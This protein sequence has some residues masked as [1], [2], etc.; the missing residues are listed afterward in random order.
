MVSCVGVSVC[1]G[2]R[3][4]RCGWRGGRCNRTAAAARRRRQAVHVKHNKSMK[5][6]NDSTDT[7]LV[8]LYHIWCFLLLFFVVVGRL[9]V[10]VRAQQPLQLRL[11]CSS[12][13]D[14]SLDST[15]L[16]STH[17][18]TS[19][20]GTPRAQG[21]T[22]PRVHRDV[23]SRTAVEVACRVLRGASAHRRLRQSGSGQRRHD[24]GRGSDADRGQDDSH[25]CLCA[26]PFSL[27]PFSLRP[28][29]ER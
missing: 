10:S 5:E 1:V 13:R 28:T 18:I 4:Q 11:A 2:V 16:D 17:R 12:R 27:S 19:Q 15:R 26:P 21:R 24:E 20:L 9:P 14:S 23:D 29:Q 6:T 7:C 8:S 3:E 25:A 22:T